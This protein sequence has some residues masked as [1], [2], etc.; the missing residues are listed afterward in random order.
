MGGSVALKYSHRCACASHTTHTSPRLTALTVLPPYGL[1][2]AHCPAPPRVDSTALAMAVWSHIHIPAQHD[3]ITADPRVP[4][5]G[6]QAGCRRHRRCIHK[7]PVSRRD[8]LW[9]VAFVVPAPR[10]G[11]GR[12]PSTVNSRRIP[13]EP[14][15]PVGGSSAYAMPFRVAGLRTQDPPHPCVSGI[16]S[17]LPGH[18]PP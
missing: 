12:R 18:I 8:Y 17:S 6:W 5:H 4:R 13:E 3:G 16:A 11:F 10:A 9:A 15:Q 7:H 2:L 14:D 1:S